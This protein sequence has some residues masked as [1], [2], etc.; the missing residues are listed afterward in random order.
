MLEKSKVTLPVRCYVEEIGYNY[1]MSNCTFLY[2][3]EWFRSATEFNDEGFAIVESFSKKKMK[4][5]I[6]GKL[7]EITE[8]ICI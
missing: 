1:I 3:S 5:V 4:I 2:P 6:Y 8:G 7:E